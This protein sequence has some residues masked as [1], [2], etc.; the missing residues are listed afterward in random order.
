MDTIL[1]KDFKCYGEH[2][3]TPKEYSRSQP[4]EVSVEIDI[5][6][7]FAAGQSDNLVYTIDYR[8]VR[9]IIQDVVSRAPHKKLIESLAEM[10]S[11]RI[12]KAL[13]AVQ[14]LRIAIM[15]TAIWENGSPGVLIRRDRPKTQQA[16]P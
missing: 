3:Y 10:I 2:G 16:R 6:S 13:P 9:G 12:F 15:K 8:V 11:R 7:L 4:F 14:S 5:D 1:I